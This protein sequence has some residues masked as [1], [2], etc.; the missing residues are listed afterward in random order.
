MGSGGKKPA[1]KIPQFRAGHAQG[2]KN[3]RFDV[4]AIESW[5]N[6]HPAW[7]FKAIDY[8]PPY[9]W[10]A[11]GV[12]AL[13][14]IVERLQHLETMT[15]GE[16]EGREHHFIQQDRVSADAKKRLRELHIEDVESL[17]SLRIDAKMRVFGIPDDKYAHVLRILW[18]D[19]HHGVCPSL[20]K[21]T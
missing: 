7:K 4:E 1:A 6:L 12:D 9:G 21:H 20:K 10:D 19:P 2:E 11:V 18:F 14:Q 16:I 17:F 5:K 3:P 8:K 15:W 13:K